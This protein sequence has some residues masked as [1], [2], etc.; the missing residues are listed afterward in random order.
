M[1]ENSKKGSSFATL[2]KSGLGLGQNTRVSA[3][4]HRSFSHTT[5]LVL[6]LA[7]HCQRHF[8]VSAGAFSD[9]QGTDPPLHG[10]PELSFCL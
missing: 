10:L 6:V 4:D 1:D 3:T 8:D 2:P 9:G 5:R 7:T